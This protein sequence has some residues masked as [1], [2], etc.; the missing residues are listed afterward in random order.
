M[1]T[2]EDAKVKDYM[3]CSPVR[4]YEWQRIAMIRQTMLEYSFSHLPFFRKEHKR[5][6]VVSAYEICRYVCVDR[7]RMSS[8][9]CDAIQE[10][11]ELNPKKAVAVRPDATVQCILNMIRADE[12]VLVL[13]PETGDLVGIA[14]A[15]DLM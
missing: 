4:T 3:V 14:N 5:W 15:F 12:P 11:A 7:K 2:V 10:K 8:K 9:L 6:F 13:H 1:A